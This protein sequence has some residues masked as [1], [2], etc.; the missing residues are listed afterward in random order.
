MNSLPCSKF[1]YCL[2][3]QVT[4]DNLFER[5]SPL[6]SLQHFPCTQSAA[7]SVKVDQAYIAIQNHTGEV[8]QSHTSNY[9]RYRLQLAQSEAT[10]IITL[11]DYTLL[12]SYTSIIFLCTLNNNYFFTL[13]IYP[14]I[15]HVTHN[16]LTHTLI[17]LSRL[18]ANLPCALID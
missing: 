17:R 6:P 7:H 14:H 13:Y 8:P 11:V 18:I 3:P 5:S 10:A 2:I 1:C 16:R 12:V 9:Q 15:F 4:S